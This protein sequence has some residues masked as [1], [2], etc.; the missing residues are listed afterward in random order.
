LNV[1]LK[2]SAANPGLLNLDA[3]VTAKKWTALHYAAMMGHITV[4]EALLTSMQ[5]VA[6]DAQAEDGRTPLML[7]AERGKIEVVRL[8]IECGADIHLTNKKGKTAVYVARERQHYDI[9]ALLTEYSSEKR[10]R[11]EN[12]DSKSQFREHL[13]KAA[14]DGNEETLK[15]LLKQHFVLNTDGQNGLMAEPKSP[16]EDSK[17]GKDKDAPVERM[18][19]GV[20]SMDNF[21][22]LH[23]AARKGHVGVVNTLL[24]YVQGAR[25]MLN[26]DAKTKSGWTPLMLAADRGRTAVV[27]L[28]L[29]LGAN[30]A[31]TT[32]D[33]KTAEDLAKEQGHTDC[34]KLL[35]KT[36]L[37]FLD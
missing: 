10:K 27:K 23:H 25:K 17:D 37:I 33:D 31:L 28:L 29:E 21:T 11:N 12:Q 1:I 32:N 13:Y 36:K 19:L 2:L 35:E 16:H 24:T 9:A 7:A 8:L 3:R 14:E 18:N 4:V 6:I 30:P 15:I 26:I 34:A 22:A 20:T 5:A